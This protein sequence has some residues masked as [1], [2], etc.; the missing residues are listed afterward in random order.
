MVR[1]SALRRGEWGERRPR[2]TTSCEHRV[3]WNLED[4]GTFCFV[5]GSL[6][7]HLLTPRTKRPQRLLECNLN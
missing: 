5:R 6:L 4:R 1:V 3:K 7:P 2:P